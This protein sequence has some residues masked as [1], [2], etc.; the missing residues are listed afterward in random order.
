MASIL[1]LPASRPVAQPSS[2][3]RSPVST[4]FL[5]ECLLHLLATALCLHIFLAQGKSHLHTQHLWLLYSNFHRSVSHINQDCFVKILIT[6][7]IIFQFDRL[8][9]PFCLALKDRVSNRGWLRHVFLSLTPR[10][11]HHCFRQSNLSEIQ[12]KLNERFVIQKM[13]KIYLRSK[14]FK[15]NLLSKNVG[16]SNSIFSLKWQ[17]WVVFSSPTPGIRKEDTAIQAH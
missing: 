5:L 8:S 16:W 11:W 7:Y 1:G 14:A 15:E 3:S 12:R 10:A 17:Q 13:A 6:K 9:S 4:C 2:C